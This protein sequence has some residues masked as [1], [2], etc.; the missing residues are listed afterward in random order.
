[1]P[2]MSDTGRYS[3]LPAFALLTRSRSRRIYCAASATTVAQTPLRAA[4]ALPS[5]G[6]TG[7][8][9]P[10]ALSQRHPDRESG[11]RH[12]YRVPSSGDELRAGGKNAATARLSPPEP[13]SRPGDRLISGPAARSCP[14]GETPQLLQRTHKD[15][16]RGRPSV[17]RAVPPGPTKRAS[18][19]KRVTVLVH[20]PRITGSG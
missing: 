18:R 2:E 9:R 5:R 3:I 7:A 1:M 11:D 17:V 12:A 16:L 20:P 4:L 10:N 15:R 19:A 8:C 13:D 6:A 14:V